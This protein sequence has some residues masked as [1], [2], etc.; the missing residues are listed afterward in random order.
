MVSV[1]CDSVGS[2]TPFISKAFNNI[3]AYHMIRGFFYSSTSWVLEPSLASAFSPALSPEV[4][5]SIRSSKSLRC[6]FS[7]LIRNYEAIQ[8]L[9]MVRN[10]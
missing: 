2:K 9:I 4:R 8:A 1:G 5:T 6:W 7:D 3:H 10:G